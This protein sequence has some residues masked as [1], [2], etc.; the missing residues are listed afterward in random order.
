[1]EEHVYLKIRA[2]FRED[3]GESL[4]FGSDNNT[5]TTTLY[6]EIMEKK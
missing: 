6:R 4:P 1:L 5:T 3:R 2:L